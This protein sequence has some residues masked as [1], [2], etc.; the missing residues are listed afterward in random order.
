MIPYLSQEVCY[1]ITAGEILFNF[2]TEN[3]LTPFLFR[4]QFYSIERLSR[5]APDGEYGPFPMLGNFLIGL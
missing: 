1:L 3:E 4:C 5:T 2:C